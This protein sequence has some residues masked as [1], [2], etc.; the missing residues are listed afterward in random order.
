MH[1][2]VAVDAGEDDAPP[3]DTLELIHVADRVAVFRAGRVAACLE[4]DRLSEEA[5]V[6]ASLGVEQGLAA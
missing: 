3:A 2:I 4:R 5:I 1:R 6:A